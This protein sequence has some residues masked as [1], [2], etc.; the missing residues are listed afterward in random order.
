MTRILIIGLACFLFFAACQKEEDQRDV[1]PAIKLLDVNR[2]EVLQFF[3]TLEVL[4]FYEDG[5]GDLGN[6][7]PDIPSLIVKD[8]RLERPDS[9]HVPP[10]APVGAQIP[11]QGELRVRLP[12]LFLLGNGSSETTNYRIRMVDRAGNESNEIQTPNIR[13]NRQ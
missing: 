9:F 3:D 11:I 5:D 1:V 7:D 2:T 6:P 4:L 10:L 12:H 8:A 13:I